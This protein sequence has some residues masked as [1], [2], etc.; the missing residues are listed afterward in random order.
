MDSQNSANWR[1][2]AVKGSAVK[3]KTGHCVTVQ[4]SVDCPDYWFSGETTVILGATPRTS[5]TVI[6]GTAASWNV[7]LD[8]RTVRQ[9][10]QGFLVVGCIRF[11]GGL[12]TER[13]DSRTDVYLNGRRVDGFALRVRPDEH[14]D[15]FHRLPIPDHIRGIHPFSLC[16]T[17]YSWSI[18]GES[19]DR[20][21]TQEI[22]LRIDQGVR[23]DI[24]YVGLLIVSSS[25]PSQVFLS[26]SWKDEQ[27]AISLLRACEDCGITVW[28]DRENMQIGSI[29][30]EET[31]KAIV[32]ARYMIALISE[33]S[34]KSDWVR[35]EIS[36][37][38]QFESRTKSVKVL[39]VILGDCQVPAELTNRLQRRADSSEDVQRI[40]AELNS[41]LNS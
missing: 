6:S 19:L 24:D 4:R 34:I 17:A 26:Y 31:R 28:V 37:G 33:H 22:D 3:L 23:W 2:Y 10:S 9:F 7:H 14:S 20:S 5:E 39:P 38:V 32:D 1:S 41:L 36:I 25:A 29:L 30:K 12:H 18:L 13:Y 35:E 11:L 16:Q 21:G 8:P 15:Y 27:V 40:A